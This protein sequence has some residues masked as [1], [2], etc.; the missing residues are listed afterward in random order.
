MSLENEVTPW[1]LLTASFRM[2]RALLAVQSEAIIGKYTLQFQYFCDWKLVTESCLLMTQVRHQATPSV[3]SEVILKIPYCFQYWLI[4]SPAEIPVIFSPFPSRCLSSPLFLLSSCGSPYLLLSI[5]ITTAFSLIHF[6]LCLH[7]CI[8]DHYGNAFQ[9]TFP[10]LSA[11]LAS[12]F[13]VIIASHLNSLWQKTYFLFITS[14]YFRVPQ[15][16]CCDF[17]LSL[18]SYLQATSKS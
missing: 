2:E 15:M 5:G 6:M 8:S 4:P 7:Q 17:P 18:T 12:A 9:I 13:P 11:S 16:H 3:C 1:G 10:P 14:S